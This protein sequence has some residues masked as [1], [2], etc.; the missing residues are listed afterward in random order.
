MEAVREERAA[1]FYQFGAFLLDPAKCVLVRNGEIVP[2]TPKAF[3]M[4]LVLVQHRGEVLEKDDLL[5]RL[6][7]DT[8]VEENNLARNISALR[9]ALDEHPNE[10]RYILTVPGRGYR[11]VAE[12]KEIES[13]ESGYSEDNSS[14]VYPSGR[15]DRCN[16][17]S[18]GINN[19]DL[20]TMNSVSAMGANRLRVAKGVTNP[21]AS[22]MRA[23]P[24]VNTR[25]RSVVAALAT[26]IIAVVVG[27]LVLFVVRQKSVTDRPPPSRRVVSSAQ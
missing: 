13:P 20:E 11:F 2:I 8:V 1:H 14:A 16:Q 24:E 22:D 6:W 10:H 12:V 23:L 17:Q 19:K 15:C 4:L 25:P 26:L 21:P 5:R 7:P 27:G 3:E 9:K 18:S